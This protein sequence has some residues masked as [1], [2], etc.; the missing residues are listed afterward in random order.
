MGKKRKKDDTEKGERERYRKLIGEKGG[1]VRS[2]M[3][4]TRGR[5]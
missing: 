4:E 2:Q 3:S 1:M 5:E